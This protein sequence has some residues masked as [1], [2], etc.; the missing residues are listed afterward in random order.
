MIAKSMTMN[1]AAKFLGKSR[2]TMYYWNSMDTLTFHHVGARVEYNTEEVVRTKFPN[3]P[4]DKVNEIIL[5][6]P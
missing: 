1:Q 5:S 4:D 6:L 3:L 2:R